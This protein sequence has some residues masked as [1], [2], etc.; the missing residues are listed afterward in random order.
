MKKLLGISLVAIMSVSAANA[1]I[2]SK[3]YVDQQDGDIEATIG[4][5]SSLK[6]TAQDNLVAAINEVVDNAGEDVEALEGRMDAVEG[7]VEVLN[8]D[9]TT[10]GSVAKSI[11]D[12]LEAYTVTG[13]DDT[14]AKQSDFT[15]LEGRVDTAEG[16]IDALQTAVGDADSGLT[17]DVADNAAAIAALDGTYATDDELTAGL[18]TKQ[19]TIDA[20][21]KLSSSLVDGLGTMSAENAADYKKTADLDSS[22]TATAGQVVTA[23]SMADGVLSQ[24]TADPLTNANYTLQEQG[25]GAGKYALT[26]IVNGSNQVTGYAW[27]LIERAQ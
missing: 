3:A 7:E 8:G 23:I 26:A 20:T 27:E 11:A 13:Q 25:V 16:D 1:E 21:H 15:T 24:T 19:D 9:A 22:T 18:A 5:L 4:T 6:T 10:S 2:A 12:A 17:K 14:Y